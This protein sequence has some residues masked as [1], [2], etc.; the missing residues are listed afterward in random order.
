MWLPRIRG[1]DDNV[2]LELL[3]KL[4]IFYKTILDHMI[5]Y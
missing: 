1:F 4:D 5:R 2:I 3:K